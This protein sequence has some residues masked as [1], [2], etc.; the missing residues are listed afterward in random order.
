MVDVEPVD[1]DVAAFLLGGV[2]ENGK[3]GAHEECVPV[4]YHLHVAANRDEILSIQAVGK[5]CDVASVGKVT[6]YAEVDRPFCS[7]NPDFGFLLDSYLAYCML[8]VQFDVLYLHGQDGRLAVPGDAEY[9]AGS[10]ES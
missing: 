6:I 5:C 4:E 8:L 1:V 2:V 3:L 9:S 7:W 10:A